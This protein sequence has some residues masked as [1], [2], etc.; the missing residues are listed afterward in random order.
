MREGV[1]APR[2]PRAPRPAR[3]L[4][5]ELGCSGPARPQSLPSPQRPSASAAQPPTPQLA[6]TGA[7]PAR[8][9]LP[10]RTQEPPRQH[11]RPRAGPSRLAATRGEGIEGGQ[12]RCSLKLVNE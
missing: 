8:G 2:Q 10:M 9:E 7:L 12:A 1:L 6:G 4:T 11:G 3:L 5:L